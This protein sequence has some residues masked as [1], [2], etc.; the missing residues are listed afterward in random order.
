MQI[1]HSLDKIY[2]IEFRAV[3]FKYSDQLYKFISKV[4]F[5]ASRGDTIAFVGPTG[6]GKSKS[7]SGLSRHDL[8][9]IT[10]KPLLTTT[11]LK[12]SRLLD[13]ASPTLR[14]MYQ[15][16]LHQT[17]KIRDYPGSMETWNRLN[18]LTFDFVLIDRDSNVVAVIELDDKSHVGPISV[19]RDQK[20]DELMK[21]LGK[22]LLRFQA[23]AMPSVDALRIEIQSVLQSGE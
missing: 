11:E 22:P 1:P 2:R 4:S 18:R 3:D 17:I 15:V 10:L 21:F 20:K 16:A 23:S 6:S 14:V 19:K 13:E 12:F 9:A 7:I 5:V 8:A